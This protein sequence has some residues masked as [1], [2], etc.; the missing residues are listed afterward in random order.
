MLDV[1]QYY[2]GIGKVKGLAV[3][4][5]SAL[6]IRQDGCGRLR[7]WLYPVTQKRINH[8]DENPQKESK[9]AYEGQQVT[10][11]RFLAEANAQY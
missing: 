4:Q 2:C 5:N 8:E 1:Q 6:R 7:L 10:A 9:D 3:G 11:E